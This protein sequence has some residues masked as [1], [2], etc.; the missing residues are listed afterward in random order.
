MAVVRLPRPPAV[1]A[2][3]VVVGAT[4]VDV[5]HPGVLAVPRAPRALALKALKSGAQV[6][7]TVALGVDHENHNVDGHRVATPVFVESHAVRIT[8][9]HG[10]RVGVWRE[11]RY[12]VGYHLCAIHGAHRLTARDLGTLGP[13][14]NAGSDMD[15]SIS[16]T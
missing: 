2:P 12:D 14:I 3:T 6:I 16:S 8:N 15:T 5:D 1:I 11:G 13:C 7:V 4:W 10:Y 9:E